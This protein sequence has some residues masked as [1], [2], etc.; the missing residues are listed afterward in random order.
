M[1][2]RVIFSL[3]VLSALA[4]C[5]RDETVRAYGGAEKTWRL[6][7]LNDA[8]VTASAT[9]TFTDDGKITGT[10]PCNGYSATMTVPYPWFEA[11]PIL[12][13]R[14]ACPDLAAETAFFDGLRAAAQ[15]EVLG[16]TMIVSNTEGLSMV[17]TATD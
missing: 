11:G 10:A 7:D 8:P 12:S 5:E 4:A 1:I 14:R 6:I 16:D 9:L 17:F 3:C 2:R 13:T 15:V